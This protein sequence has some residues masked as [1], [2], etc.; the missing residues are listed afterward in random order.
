MESQQ[1]SLSL[2]TTFFVVPTLTFLSDLFNPLVAYP[3]VKLAMQVL[4]TI[5]SGSSRRKKDG[6]IE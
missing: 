3:V 4:F 1:L 5:H 2:P 6:A